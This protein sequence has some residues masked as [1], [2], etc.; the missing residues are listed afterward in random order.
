M[1]K[2]LLSLFLLLSLLGC[3]QTKKS[4]S[5]MTLSFITIPKGDA[6]IL[7][8]D[9]DSYYL[10]DCGKASDYEQIAKVLNQKNIQKL[11]GIILSH[12]HRDHA[13]SFAQILDNYQV[14]NV[15]ISA[16]DSITYQ[17]IDVPTIADEHGVNIVNVNKNDRLTIKDVVLEFWIPDEINYQEENDNSLIINIKHGENSI[18]MMGDATKGEEMK[19]AQENQKVK[20]DILKFGHH[21]EDN[22]S[23]KKFLMSIT[24]KI[25][26][27][28]ANSEANPDS[29]NNKLDD[30]IKLFNLEVYD[31]N[32]DALAYDFVSDGQTFQIQEIR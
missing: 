16:I 26:I 2:I 28:T 14:D 25:A 10:I 15:Y 18:L 29:Y 7:D 23:S 17:Y 24:P 1:K 31:A 27:K 11:D 32:T 19:Y 20:V 4:E 3:S 21:G 13:G 5:T 30:R 12:G 8:V 6:F 22:A 9:N